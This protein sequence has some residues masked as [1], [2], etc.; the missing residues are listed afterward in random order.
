MIRIPAAVLVLA[1]LPLAAHGQPLPDLHQ[2]DPA[3]IPDAERFTG[4]PPELV[5]I[6]GT[7]RG[8]HWDAITTVAYSPG[9][10]LLVTGGDRGAIRI[11]DAATLRERWGIQG[12]E[13]GVTAV[14]FAPDGQWLA[15]ASGHWDKTLKR[16]TRGS[17]KLWDT[18]TGKQRGA[19]DGHTALVSAL[20]VSPDGK[21]LASASHDRTVRLWDLTRIPAALH[22]ELHGHGDQVTAITFA[23][24]GKTVVSGD[25]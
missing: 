23:Q 19:L 2:L 21:L 3:A 11:W 12:H 14:V 16:I 22:A 15:S 13:H 20:A 10:E 5:A 1:A 17:V 24:D 18:A 8:R 25:R 9:G 7:N 4:Q 6:L